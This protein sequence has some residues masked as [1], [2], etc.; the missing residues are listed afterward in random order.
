[1]IG[2]TR[3]L[4]LF[5]SILDRHQQ[6]LRSRTSADS[7][8]ELVEFS[9]GSQRFS[10]RTPLAGYRRSILNALV[11]HG[12]SVQQSPTADCHIAIAIAGEDGWPDLPDW[13][14]QCMRDPGLHLAMEA[15]PYRY[16]QQPP[17]CWQF[18]DQ[19]SRCGVQLLRS[20]TSLPPWDGGAP[21]RNFLHWHLISNVCG[22]L[23]AGTLG[24]A[25]QGILLAGPGGSG[26]S[27]TVLAG[28]LHGLQSV[29]DDYVLVRLDQ[30]VTAYPLFQTLKQDPGGCERLGIP[31]DSALR[32]TLNW[33]GKHQFTLADLGGDQPV[34]QLRIR[35]LCL[36]RISGTSTTRF[37]PVNG[38]DAFLA[39]A[40]SGLAQMPG[41]RG[42][43]FSFCAAVA[44]SLP[45]YRLELGSDP[46][47]IS[48]SIR[49]FLQA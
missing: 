28:L 10:C 34:D 29:G 33:Q 31:A 2:D 14:E 4:R 24:H 12:A 7:G 46:A 43:L 20:A 26:K 1:M 49:A 6:I 27:G 19:R 25:G 21:L 15:T 18:F 8:H 36:P 17:G 41:D 3:I 47:E 22:L 16:L 37:L 32:R 9:L 35:A 38:K 13:A 48:T 11:N 42:I 23:H 44:R 39:L 45:T 5:E 40:P 30:D